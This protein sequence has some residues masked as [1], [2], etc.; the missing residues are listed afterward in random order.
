MLSVMPMSAFATNPYLPS[1]EYIPDGEPHVFNGRVY[2]YGSHDLAD[3]YGGGCLGDYE[4]WSAPVDDLNNW[5]HHGTMYK[6]TQDADYKTGMTMLASDCAYKN[7][8]YYLYYSPGGKVSVAISDDPAGPF[9]YYGKV[10]YQNGDVMKESFDPAILVDDDGRNYLYTGGKSQ[11]ME[12]SNDMLTVISEP[13][14]LVPRKDEDANTVGCITNPDDLKGCAFYEGTSIRKFGST[15]YLV[16]CNEKTHEYSYATSSSPVGPFTFRGI[17]ISNAGKMSDTDMATYPWGNIHGGMVE[18]KGQMYIFYHRQANGMGTR[19]WSGRQACAEPI[20]V[21]PDGSIVRAEMTSQGLNGGPL[22][23]F[24]QYCAD[25][26]CYLRTPEGAFESPQKIGPYNN[27]FSK[28]LHGITNTTDMSIAGFKYLDFGNEADLSMNFMTRIRA[29]GFE[30]KVGIYIDN[31]DSGRKI[32]EFA[33][34]QNASKDWYTVTT[35][36]ENVT[37]THALYLVFDITDSSATDKDYLCDVSTFQ[38]TKNVDIGMTVGVSQL[39]EGYAANVPVTVSGEGLG[40]ISVKILSKDGQTLYGES[41]MQGD[42]K[43]VVRIDAGKKISA[44]AYDVVVFSGG[45][46][47][48]A[49]LK[50]VS[51]SESIWSPE[52]VSVSEKVGIKFSEEISA[53]AAKFEVKIGGLPVSAAIVADNTV[54]TNKDYSQLKSGDVIIVSGIKY[55]ALFPSYSFTFMITNR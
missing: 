32:G 38:F 10:V 21:N 49:E 29:M 41:A 50:V 45:A 6:K 51:P 36:V 54:L 53:S 37:G 33:I 52:I 2:I 24:N 30:G 47:K 14:R 5:T 25:I 3:V 46:V 34:P 42:G 4:A 26:A 18:I 44:G 11:V 27:E 55:P 15:Y 39:V 12:L 40:D 9:E 35:P 22:N 43:A 19:W 20:T 31:P 1:W 8:K 13:K 23:A 48:A 16:W 17:I 7:G 28:D